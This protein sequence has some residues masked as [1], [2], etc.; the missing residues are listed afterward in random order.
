MNFEYLRRY[1]Y[2]L[3]AVIIRNPYKR[4]EF[5]RKNLYFHKQGENCS[6]TIFNFGVEPHLLSFGNNV[7]VAAGVRFICHDIIGDVVKDK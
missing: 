2:L 4:T 1:Y 6:F 7:K 3:R 5:F